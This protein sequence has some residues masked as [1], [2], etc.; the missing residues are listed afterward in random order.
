MNGLS[1]HNK[2]IDIFNN[3]SATSSLLLNREAF[4]LVEEQT[5]ENEKQNLSFFNGFNDI[6]VM[7]YFIHREKHVRKERNREDNTKQEYTRIL[8]QFYK[9]LEDNR[10]FFEQE[11]S[12][13]DKHSLLKNLRP[14]HIK[15]FQK[16]LSTAPLGKGGKPYKA[17]TINQKN[18]VIKSFLSFLFDNGY[19]QH[20]LHK[21][22][23]STS[24]SK[25]EIPNRDL[26]YHE[27]KQ[28]LDFYKTNPITLGLLTTL[29]MTGL[30]IQEIAKAKMKD[31][32]YDALSGNYRLRGV[33]KG[34]TPFDELIHE[35]NFERIMAYRKRRRM[36]TTLD[37]T[38][39]SP[40]FATPKG[41]HY[42]HKNLSN[43][44]IRE[45]KRTNL[46]FLNHRESKIT[47]HSFRHFWAIYS[48]Q[49]GADISE[50]QKGLRHK[51]RRTTERYLEK[52]LE[53]EREAALRWDQS[54][55]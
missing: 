55:F 40:L 1:V 6:A 21:S 17:A 4:H 16:Y 11:V 54:K 15:A 22:M 5:V 30:R 24:I 19:I 42:N 29:A 31:L 26:Y 48:R 34:G 14:R 43:F 8:L 35:V 32:Y 50:I 28:L 46:P 23:L 39:E 38:D 10:S 18:T 3:H 33:G 13:Y 51:D 47:P 9:Y 36:S 12:D 41:K 25:D 44:I 53:R 7:Y 52:V 45:V 49:M 20:P 2:D 27:V 37:P